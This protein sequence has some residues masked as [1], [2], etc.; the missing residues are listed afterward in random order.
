MLRASCVGQP[1]EMVNL[2]LAPMKSISTSERIEKALDRLR[3]R[4]GVSGGLATKPK[5][6]DIRN[7]PKVTFNTASLKLFNEDL[8][9]LEV[10]AYVH[11]EVEKLC[12]QMLKDV[13]NRLTGTLKRRYLDYLTQKRLDLNRPSFESLRKFV[14]H[15]LSVMTSDYAQ[16]FFNADEKDKSREFNMSRGPVRIRKVAVNPSDKQNDLPGPS[17]SVSAQNQKRL[18]L[19][20]VCNDSNSRHYLAECETLKNFS[21]ERKK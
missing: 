19:C 4:Y 8:N 17:N 14:V 1:R 9:M 3:E 6:I 11:D 10:F 2:F 15:E 21:N 12:E 16:T 5:I 18:P 7:G 13:A 20:F